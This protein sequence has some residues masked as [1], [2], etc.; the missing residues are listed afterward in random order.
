MQC[1]RPIK[2]GFDRSGSI[3]FSQK[4]FDK[5][6]ESFAFPC[7]KCLACRLNIPREKAI[8]SIHEASQH[9]DN[10]FLT[11]TYAPH[12]LKSPWLQYE[13]WQVFIRALRDKQNDS[14]PESLHH[15]YKISYMVT[16]EYGDQ[17]KRP[18]WHAI[19]YN[20]KP[21]DSKIYRTTERG[22]TVWTSDE[23]TGLWKKGLVEFGSVTMESA[24]YVAR[25]SAK[26]LVH[27][28]DGHQYEPIHKTS[29]ARAIGRSWIEKYYQQTFDLGYVTMPDGSQGKIPRY[30]LDWAKK[31]QPKIWERYIT[32]LRDDIISESVAK[33]R[34]EELEYISQSL[35]RGPTRPLM[36]TPNDVKLTILKQKFK[37]LQ[38]KLKL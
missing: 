27:G 30:Y 10:I 9:R 2:A 20:Y 3:T 4:T 17:G 19:L 31:H 34:R 11:L 12:A 18:H 16:G 6:I 29:S 26:K 5:S 35:T 1:I 13:D 8:R 38:E 32:T 25:Y 28:K 37:T 14:V 36:P 22:E 7:R 24:G 15:Y 21:S 33:N 23:L